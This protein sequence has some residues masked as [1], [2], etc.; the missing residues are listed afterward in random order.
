M[1]GLERKVEEVANSWI[2]K[3]SEESASKGQYS[4]LMRIDFSDR[5][6]I[7]T[8]ETPVDSFGKITGF[9]CRG[10]TALFDAV[11]KGIDEYQKYENNKDTSMLMV[12]V[13]DGE[14]NSSD[15]EVVRNIGQRLKNKQN[16]GNWSF[17]FMLPPGS[18][19][20]FCSR[21]SIPTDNAVEWEASDEGLEEVRETTS[22][23]F[24]NYFNARS[25]GAQSVNAFYSQTNMAQL[26]VSVVKK[27]LDNIAHK[28]DVYD[29]PKEVVISD[30]VAK[31]TGA[32]YKAGQSYYQLTKKEEVQPTKDVLIMEK[33]KS[34]IY[35][36]QEARDLIGLHS[37]ATDY[38][39]PGNH[40]NYDIFI[41]STSHNR[42]LVRG[43][44]LIVR[45]F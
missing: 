28:C 16:L 19:S 20:T 1:F 11:S 17:I 23:G 36:G 39:T 9:S 25:L 14:E 24:T 44:K 34:A 29:V 7:V 2:D 27:A 21:Y 8:R 13:T 37:G 15:Y 10:N 45:K 26:P 22:K 42:I 32:P 38:V 35:A 6:D 12:V 40:A 43:S 5:A 33:G 41:K 30:F 3:I 18:K 31:K 4:T